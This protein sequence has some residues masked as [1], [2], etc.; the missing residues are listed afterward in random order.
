MLCTRTV[1]SSS[2]ETEEWGR[3][4]GTVEVPER[5]E[6]INCECHVVTYRYSLQLNTLRPPGASKVKGVLDSGTA[7]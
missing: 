2:V 4:S 7:L 1:K 3:G 5:K 6:I